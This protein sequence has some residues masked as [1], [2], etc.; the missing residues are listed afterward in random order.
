M[1]A[2]NEDRLIA[3][4]AIDEGKMVSSSEAAANEDEEGGNLE[5]EAREEAE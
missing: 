4:L 5:M 1:Q 2:E 3:D